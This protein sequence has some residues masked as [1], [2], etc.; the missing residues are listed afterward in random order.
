MGIVLKPHYLQLSQNYD[1][2]YQGKGD[3]GFI[4]LSLGISKVLNKM[5]VGI[6][7]EWFELTLLDFGVLSYFTIDKVDTFEKIYGED[8]RILGQ[9]HRNINLNLNIGYQVLPSITPMIGVGAGW[10]RIHALSS[11]SKKHYDLVK[12]EK[13]SFPHVMKKNWL[14]T[15]FLLG[16]KL[17]AGPVFFYVGYKYQRYWGGTN[18][19]LKILHTINERDYKSE[20]KESKALKLTDR[21][22]FHSHGLQ[23]MVGASF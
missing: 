8:K 22:L 7:L 13:K 18:N 11:L 21:S 20:L 6:N 5:D 12:K 14:T 3:R 10:S 23:W 16:C 1:G 4:G 15:Q 19:N 9:Y 17:N 2:M